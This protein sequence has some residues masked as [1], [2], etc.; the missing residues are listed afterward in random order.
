[1]PKSEGGDPLHVADFAGPVRP[2][3][4]LNVAAL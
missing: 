3:W 4:C 1:M 2:L